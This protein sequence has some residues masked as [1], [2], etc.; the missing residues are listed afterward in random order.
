MRRT[1]GLRSDRRLGADEGGVDRNDAEARTVRTSDEP[2][3]TIGSVTRVSLF[4]YRA[5]VER[6]RATSPST[7]FVYL[8]TANRYERS[9]PERERY[10]GR[11]RTAGRAAR[12]AIGL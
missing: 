3:G 11:N 6:T 7:L 4:R 1:R 5:E 2:C 12:Y 10:T 8:P 9:T